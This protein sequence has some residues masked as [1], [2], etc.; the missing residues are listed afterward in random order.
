MANKFDEIVYVDNIESINSTGPLTLIELEN[1]YALGR[2]ELD[3]LKKQ[4]APGEIVVRNNLAFATDLF[5]IYLFD[6]SNK[7]DPLLAGYYFDE[8]QSFGLCVDETYIYVAKGDHGLV[9]YRSL[10]NP[11]ASL[12]TGWII[13]IVS[14]STLI[15]T[16]PLMLCRRKRK[17]KIKE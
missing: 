1:N 7:N 2:A 9:L 14:T 8:T 13:L 10:I 6:I 5:G 4:H 12:G 3:A 11:R 17:M 16:V 15:I